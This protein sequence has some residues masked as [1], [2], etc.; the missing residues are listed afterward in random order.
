MATISKTLSFFS[1]TAFS[2]DSRTMRSA[3]SAAMRS[4]NCFSTRW[5]GALPLRKPG[6]AAWAAYSFTT[7]ARALAASSAVAETE[8]TE[9]V[10]D[11]DAM[12]AFMAGY[13]GVAPA[14]RWKSGRTF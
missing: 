8:R 5:A 11:S 7:A 6:M 4:A 2:K 14:C 10:L 12:S 1:S 9:R 13:A 3:A